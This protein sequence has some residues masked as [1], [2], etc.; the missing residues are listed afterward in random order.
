MHYRCCKV[1]DA[2][3]NCPV[4]LVRFPLA[5]F[6]L[7]T[8]CCNNEIMI[9]I[10]LVNY[11]RTLSADN[12]HAIIKLEV[13]VAPRRERRSAKALGVGR[14]PL[15]IPPLRPSLRRTCQALMSTLPILCLSILPDNEFRG[16]ISMHTLAL[17][18][19]G[20]SSNGQ[21]P[22]GTS[23][24]ITLQPL[25]FSTLYVF[26]NLYHSLHYTYWTTIMAFSEG[27]TCNTSTHQY[28]FLHII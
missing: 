11:F 14:K 2:V 1:T 9:I 13:V 19:M 26:D 3:G 25:P 16:G 10:A 5:L 8:R 18:Y 4:S 27:A 12:R 17:A 28:G 7:S 15:S 6:L 24:C 23:I 21:L 20:S 22:T